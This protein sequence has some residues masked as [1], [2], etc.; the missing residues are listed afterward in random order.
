MNIKNKLNI[1]KKY[2]YVSFDVFDTLV[3]RN[4]NKPEMIFSLVEKVAKENGLISPKCD[5]V[6]DRIMAQKLAYEIS[7]YQEIN[8]NEIYACINDQYLNVKQQLKEME[9][10]IELDNIVP[11]KEI[12]EIYNYCINENK[13][14][15]VISDMYL[16]TE[17]IMSILIQCGYKN[18]NNIFISSEYRAR[19]STGKL[20]K[21]VQ[22][23]LGVKNKDIIHIGDN[24]KS[25]FL[26]AIKSG[27][28][29]IHYKCNKISNLTP[30]QN[31]YDRIG[32]NYF[33]YQNNEY[34]K[35]G[36]IYLG[37]VMFQ[38]C[39]WLQDIKVKK[40]IDK[41]FFL[42]R[43]GLFIRECYET[44][45]G[46]S[47][48]NIYLYISRKPVRVAAVKPDMSV[49]QLLEM[50]EPRVDET[51]ERFFDKWNLEI[52]AYE[53]VLKR[54]GVEKE[55]LINNK[56]VTS[57]IEN[58]MPILWNNSETGKNM[59][60]DYL[61]KLDYFDNNS[62]LVDIGWK[63][64]MQHSLNNI[65]P[66]SKKIGIYFGKRESSYQDES[67]GFITDRDN[68]LE[69][70]TI[71]YETMFM[72]YHGTTVGYNYDKE[73]DEI[74]PV[75]KKSEFDTEDYKK[76]REIQKGALYYIQIFSNNTFA[77]DLLESNVPIDRFIQ[78]AVNP[79]LKCLKLLGNLPYYDEYVSKLIC[80]N[81]I[82][83]FKNGLVNSG[84]KIGFLKKTIG[85]KHFPYLQT[86]KMLKKRGKKCH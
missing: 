64:S 73:S 42:A 39:N 47:G 67:Y 4:V 66:Q 2:K 7:K 50:T 44:F 16:S 29:A 25:D 41:L 23:E 13:K 56:N 45:M 86:Y 62:A 27:I 71:L 55:S 21:I 53:D 22:N 57:V 14:I 40:N 63:G 49:K 51:I 28:R 26:M 83:N 46:K 72:P 35:L 8:L 79:D 6:K 38:F 20:Y 11:N 33:P 36:Y 75:L 32:Y 1:I 24:I 54:Y 30:K 76:I 58:V 18:I 59:L 19:K 77:P 43:E 3:Y 61:N 34:Y 82:K 60:K 37:P 70:G 17:N 68:E 84:W 48:E 80:D 52:N 31:I 9:L 65:F 69:A 74:I 81:N 12:K 10:K 85:I 78:L 5:F 15:I